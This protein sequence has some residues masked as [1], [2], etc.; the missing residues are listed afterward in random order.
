MPDLKLFTSES[1]SEGHPDKLADQISDAILDE[2]LRQDVKSRVAVETLLTRG[3]AVIAGEVTTQGYVEIPDVVRAAINEAGYTKVDY[4]IDG[5][6]TGVL[7]ALQKQSPDI[8]VGVDA[9]GKG[10]AGVVPYLPPGDLPM[11]RPADAAPPSPPPL[12]P[13]P[14]LGAKR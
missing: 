8:A 1:V 14:Q 6:T 11:H 7:V 4:G 10:G 3:L 2:L 12:P 9:S 13:L 5:D